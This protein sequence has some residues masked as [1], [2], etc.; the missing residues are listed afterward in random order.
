MSDRLGLVREYLGSLPHDIK[1]VYA[2]TSIRDGLVEKLGPHVKEDFFIL[3]V[4]PPGSGFKDRH[5]GVD[6]FLAGWQDWTDPYETYLFE[7]GDV[8]EVGEAVLAHGRQT[9]TLPGGAEAIDMPRITSVWWFEGD[10]IASIEFHLDRELA[11]E[12][13]RNKDGA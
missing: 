4:G 10:R 13:A 1:D 5:E 11:L 8:E 7:P 3:L 9:A 2:D 12:R 6:G